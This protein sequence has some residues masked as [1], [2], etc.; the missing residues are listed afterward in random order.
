MPDILWAYLVTFG[1]ALVEV[2]PGTD[3]AAIEKWCKTWN[4]HSG[5]TAG[6]S[7]QL[8][9]SQQK[10]EPISWSSARI[11]FNAKNGTLSAERDGIQAHAN[12]PGL[13]CISSGLR[14][15]NEL[16]REMKT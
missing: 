15:L 16:K 1:W 12:A 3:D 14:T 13:H 5:E 8:L 2:D 11:K 6:V 4:S 7:T 10:A 9:V